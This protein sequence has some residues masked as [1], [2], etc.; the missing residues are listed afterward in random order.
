MQHRVGLAD[1]DSAVADLESRLAETESFI[2]DAAN[3]IVVSTGDS[4][5]MR[6]SD[7]ITTTVNDINYIYTQ[8][9][10][11]F[12]RLDDLE[13][14]AERGN[15]P[16]G[17]GAEDETD[18]PE[19]QADKVATI[20]SVMDYV[21]LMFEKKKSDEPVDDASY[22]YVG[23]YLEGSEPT[24]MR[25]MSKFKIEDYPVEGQEGVFALS[26]LASAESEFFDADDNDIYTYFNFSIPE[27]YTLVKCEIDDP[28]VGLEEKEFD[29]MG[30]VNYAGDRV[31][32]T[33]YMRAA[34]EGDIW[35]SGFK[36]KITISKN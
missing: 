7:A 32:Y 19:G 21:N 5:T 8:A 9:S 1:P 15:F 10:G 13:G 4:D 12:S 29:N 16:T 18:A 22:I 20:Q 30:T 28:L 24:L 31:N 34:A 23:G 6:L 35:Q 17:E 14:G 27:G 2:S 25:N 26:V 33:N 36:Y 11:I 3:N